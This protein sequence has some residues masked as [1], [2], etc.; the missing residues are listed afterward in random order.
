MLPSSVEPR[1]CVFSVALWDILP[2]IGQTLLSWVSKELSLL[3]KHWHRV[4]EEPDMVMLNSSE[5]ETPGFCLSFSLIVF[6]PK[7]FLGG[8]VLWL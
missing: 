5:A 2:D 8:G 4:R 7:V 1:K 3:P 6:I